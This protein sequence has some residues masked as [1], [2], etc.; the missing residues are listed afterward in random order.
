MQ[1]I[2]KVTI[3]KLINMNKINCNRVL[4]LLILVVSCLAT[5]KGQEDTNIKAKLEGI[6]GWACYH[7]TYGGWYSIKTNEKEGACDTR[8]NEIIPPKYEAVYFDGNGYKDT[9]LIS[10]KKELRKI[11]CRHFVFLYVFSLMGAS[12]PLAPRCFQV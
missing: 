10:K 2:Y 8:G 4:S 1:Q 3:M 5:V 7:S 12:R 6:Y 9:V 11:N